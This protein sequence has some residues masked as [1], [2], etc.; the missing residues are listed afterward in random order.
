MNILNEQTEITVH[1]Y[2]QTNKIARVCEDPEQYQD[3]NDS[4]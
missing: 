1:L 2:E 4:E 3:N